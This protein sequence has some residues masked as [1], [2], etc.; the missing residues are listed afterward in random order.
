MPEWDG[1][2]IL[3]EAELDKQKNIGTYSNP[4]LPLKDDLIDL[5]I[6]FITK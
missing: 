3:K 5:I 6:E 2:H 4:E 1:M